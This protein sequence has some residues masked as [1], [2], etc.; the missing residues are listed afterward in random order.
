ME[1]LGVP[2]G[3]VIGEALDML[4]EARIEEGP[5]TEAEAE[6]RLFA[7]AAERGITAQG[8]GVTR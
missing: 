1:L 2:P 7:W 4:L 6:T 5:M 8:G 3:R